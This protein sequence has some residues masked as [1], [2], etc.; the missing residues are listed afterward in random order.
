[1]THPLVSAFHRAKL[2][3]WKAITVPADFSELTELEVFVDEVMASTPQVNF[4][5]GFFC[6]YNN[7]V[8]FIWLWPLK[9]AWNVPDQHWQYFYYD[10]EWVYR[11]GYER[12]HF[13]S[14]TKPDLS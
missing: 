9:P 5:V 6:G 1:M 8:F 4:S 11:D 2:L 14:H 10:A 12:H 3:G 7:K 13:S